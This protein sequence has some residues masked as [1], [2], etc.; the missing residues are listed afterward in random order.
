MEF[1]KGKIG[2]KVFF[3]ADTPVSRE[4]PGRTVKGATRAFETN[5]PVL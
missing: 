4:Y 3:S 1:F 2:H 5:C